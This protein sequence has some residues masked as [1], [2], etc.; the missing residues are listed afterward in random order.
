MRTAAPYFWL[1]PELATGP[2]CPPPTKL[3]R[4]ERFY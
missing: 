3:P 1:M 4:A 2:S